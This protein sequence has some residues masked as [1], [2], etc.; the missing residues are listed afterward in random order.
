MGTVE[1]VCDGAQADYLMVRKPDGQ[2]ILVPN[3]EPFVSRPDFENGTI[4][5]LNSS[6]LE[7]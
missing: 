4:E 2:T 7:I 6:L 1:S 5:L 3:M